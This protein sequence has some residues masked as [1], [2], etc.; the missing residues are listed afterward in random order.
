M[1]SKATVVVVS[2]DGLLEQHGFMKAIPAW[3]GYGPSLANPCR[4]LMEKEHRHRRRE[5]MPEVLALI[6]ARGGSKGIPQKN[7]APCAGRPL[8]AWTIDAARDSRHVS[9]ILVSTDDPDIAAVARTHGAEVPFLR[10][11]ELSRDDSPHI[12]V[13]LHALTWLRE[14]QG[15][16]PDWLVLLQPTSPLRLARDVDDAVDLALARDAD[17][18]VSLAPRDDLHLLR[19]L[20]EA[21]R[22][23]PQAAYAQGYQPRQSARAGHV[24]NGAVFLIKTSVLLEK[25]TFYTDRTY[26][27]VMPAA[28]SLDVDTPFDL[29]LAELLLRERAS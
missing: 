19:D 15:R 5:N 21:G 20:D 3:V 22:I 16:L 11:P 13:L 29:K 1:A 23:L 12:P 6:T 10:P 2:A 8:I 28:R 7:I 9:G 24:V 17:A 27:L 25:Q 14:H 4:R 26:A 18:V